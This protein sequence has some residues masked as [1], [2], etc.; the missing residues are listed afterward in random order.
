[1]KMLEKDPNKRIELIDIF[2]H[3][4]IA[5]FKNK[6]RAY[7]RAYECSSDSISESE[8]EDDV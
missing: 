5:K 2:E 7:D 8:E 1:M 6:D 4:W 3:P